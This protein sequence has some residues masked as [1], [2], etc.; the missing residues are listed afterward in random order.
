[1]RSRPRFAANV[2]GGPQLLSVRIRTSS[3]MSAGL[4]RYER[5]DRVEVIAPDRL[6]EPYRVDESRPARCAAASCEHKLR[7]GQ[8]RNRGVNRFGMMLAHFG[9]RIRIS[10]VDGAEEFLGLT[11]KLLQVGTDRQTANGHDEPPR[12]SPWS[13]GVGQRRFRSRPNV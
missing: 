10:G 4:P 8:L 12:T 1:M 11:V 6:R 5:L 7:I 9:D 2:I 3:F 13:A